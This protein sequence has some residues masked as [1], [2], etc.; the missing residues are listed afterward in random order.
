VAR[1]PRGTGFGGS[2]R[3]DRSRGGRG[4][5]ADPRVALA[6]A[7][8]GGRGPRR[9]DGCRARESERLREIAVTWIEG[10][11]RPRPGFTVDR[12]EAKATVEMAGL[13]F[14]LKLDR[15]D[16]LPGGGVA[17]ID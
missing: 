8:P 2:R 6:G 4:A 10:Y 17:S 14:R 9:G 5:R 1:S 15:V 16:A 11:E 7:G 13:T 12:T 3:A